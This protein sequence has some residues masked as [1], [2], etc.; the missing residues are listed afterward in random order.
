[1]SEVQ[2]V[3]VVAWTSLTLG[4]RRDVLSAIYI[5]TAPVLRQWASAFVSAT[6]G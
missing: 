2:A 3:V 4:A 6:S 5:S 1:V